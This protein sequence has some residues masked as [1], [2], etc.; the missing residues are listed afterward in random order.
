MKE[1]ILGKTGLKSAEIGLGCMGMSEF[2]GQADEAESVKVIRTA[3]EKGV[4]MLDTADMY[5]RGHNEVLVGKAVQGIRDRIVLATKFGIVRSDDPEKRGVNGSPEYVKQAC[6]A[7]LKRLGVDIIDLYYMHRKD[8]STEIEETVSAMAEL[9]KA[10]KVRHIGLSEVSAHNLK[11]AHAVYPIT[12]VQAEYSLWTRDIEENGLLDTCRELGIGIVAYSPLGRGFL[13]GSIESA[14]SLA[15]DDFRR[16]N[17]RFMGEN[18]RKNAMM[19]AEYKKM[20]ESI[21]CTPAQLAIAW[22]LA[23]GEDIVPIPGTKRLKYL[24]D[25]INAANFR[26]TPEQVVRLEKIIDWKHIAGDRYG[27]EGMKTLDK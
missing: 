6:D 24:E 1:R 21:G 10:G 15:P 16:N 4:T 22:I 27:A 3:V 11:R 20:A 7:S 12:A 5:G 18:M 17:P 14:E 26:L 9:I 19:L 8:P 2:Y 25:N 23:K 13:S